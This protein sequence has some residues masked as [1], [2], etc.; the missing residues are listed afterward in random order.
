MFHPF[1][2]L[3]G[4]VELPKQFTFPFSYTPHPLCIE[5]S[6]EVREYLLTLNQW[7][8]ELVQGKMF[9]V[10]VVQTEDGSLGYLSAFSGQIAGS[11]LHD[12]FVP[13]VYDLNSSTSFFRAEESLISE[14][15]RKIDV[16]QNDLRYKN[17]LDACHTVEEQYGA[18]KKSWKERLAVS[19]VERDRRRENHLSAEEEQSLI[20]ESQFLKAEA[21]RSLKLVETKLL[22]IQ[23]EL[24][25]FSLEIESLKEKRKSMSMDL[26]DRLFSQFRFL[27]AKGEEASLL[28]LFPNTIPPSG[29][30]E[31]AAPKLLQY[32]F[33]NHYKPICMAEFWWGKSPKSIVRM[34]GSFYPACHAKC[35]PILTFMIQG[36]DVEP[37]P[38]SEHIFSCDDLSAVYEDECL[39][40]VNKPAGMLS[41]PGTSDLPSVE[42]LLKSLGRY[43]YIKVVH[44]LDMATSGLLVVAKTEDIYVE[45]QKLFAQRRVRKRYLAIL[46]GIIK[47]ERGEIDLPICPDVEHRP[48]QMVDYTYGKPSLTEFE[49]IED[50]SGKT[51][52]WFYPHTGRT[53]QLRLHSAHKNGLSTPIVGDELYGTKA[54]RLYLQAQKIQFEHPQTGQFI[55]LEIPAEF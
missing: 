32:A 35:K 15:N 30:G 29:A 31:C 40:V 6:R 24:D 18:L 55:E 44:R 41:V 16:I 2:C 14:I 48:C 5:A 45:M 10:L 54:D 34:H 52:V 1:K 38:L 50:V 9:G 21:K 39:I 19:K 25:V 28:D 51:K 17:L 11:Y 27:N 46:D 13:P 42:S 49:K 3:E 26:Q 33:Q 53:H 43:E 22:D 20:K 4:K 23:K 37:N 36:L 47:K 8:E 7:E 12:F